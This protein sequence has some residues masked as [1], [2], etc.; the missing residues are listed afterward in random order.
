M[1]ASLPFSKSFPGRTAL[2]ALIAS[3]AWRTVPAQTPQTSVD[4]I[5]VI[6]SSHWDLGFLRPPDEQM[7]V[8][9]PHLDAVLAACERH[10]DFRWTI[11]SVWQ[12]NAWLERTQDPKQIA[13]MQKLL[14]AGQIELS[15]ADGSQHTEFIGSEEL[16]RLIYAA[17]KAHKQFGIQ[18][19]IAMMNDTPGFSSRVVQTLAT[20]GVP[21]MMTGSNI[22]LGGGLS[23]SRG[24]MPFF[25]QGPDGSK[26]LVWQTQG[27]NGGYTEGVADYHLAPAVEDPYKHTRFVPKELAGFSDLEI[28]RRSVD[29]LLAEYQSAGYHHS[30]LAVMFLHDGVGPADEENALLPNVRAWNAAGMKPRLV[31]ATPSEFFHA[32][33]Q[34]EDVSAF[35]TLRG[36]WNGLWARVKTNSPALSAEALALQDELPQAETLRSLLRMKQQAPDAPPAFD[37]AYKNLFIYDEHNGAAQ[38]SWPDVMTRAEVSKQNEEYVDKLADATN[39]AQQQMQAELIDLTDRANKAAPAQTLLVYNPSSWP[40]SR[41]TCVK[42][43]INS[44]AVRDLATNSEAHSQT[45]QDG[46]LCFEAA[47]VPATGYRTYALSATKRSSPKPASST[48]LESPYY[49]VE[50]DGNGNVLRITD[51]QQGEIVMMDASHGDEVG[52][53]KIDGNSVKLEATAQVTLHREQGPL[54]ERLTIERQ[55]SQWPRTV[56]SL[57]QLEPKIMVSETLDRAHMPFVPYGKDSNEYS[58]GF[59]VGIPESQLLVEDG[60]GVRPFPQYVLPG[61]RTDALVPRHAIAWSNDKRHLILSQKDSFFD[62][63]LWNGSN[64]AGVDVVAMV[65]SDQ[66]KTKDQGIQTFDAFEPHFDSLRTFSFT[67]QYGRG[68]ATPVAIYQASVSDDVNKT[69]L[70]PTTRTASS[71]RSSLLSISGAGVVVLDLKPSEDGDLQHYTLRLQEIEGKQQRIAVTLPA[72]VSSVAQTSLTEDVVLKDG[73]SL[74]SIELTPHQTLTLRLTVSNALSPVQQGGQH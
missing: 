60:N 38:G 8:M 58:F 9:K 64:A 17:R 46:S 28:T 73:L 19:T 45:M 62:K 57:P 55:N 18:P 43:N 26:I 52:T 2:L 74:R 33:T 13:Q 16:N 4:T 6:P 22:A 63:L 7:A 14:Q 34:R 31:V 32:L 1:M 65:K 25:W 69:A 35:P 40:A 50:F 37:H 67:L 59:H 53:L 24:M 72:G 42:P 29:K 51:K 61:A 20:S 27:K 44:N 3:A 49:R 66:T 56:I 41:V 54:M 30:L 36:D 39:F 47:D 12:L 5:Y 21:F 48:T 68:P 10:A 11:E 23:V 70:L 71:P 15:A